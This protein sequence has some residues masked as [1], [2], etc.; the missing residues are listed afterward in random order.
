MVFKSRLTKLLSSQQNK[1]S[2]VGLFFGC[3]TYIL[4]GQ[5]I[6]GFLPVSQ[7]TG[8]NVVIT[9]TGFTTTTAVRFGGVNAASFTVNSASQITATVPTGALTGDVTVVT[10]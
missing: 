4:F 1:R 10:G 6:T 5:T 3:F 7:L 2:F 8:K 9:G